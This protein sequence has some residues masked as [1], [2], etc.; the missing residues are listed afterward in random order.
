[1]K[2]SHEVEH[3][4]QVYVTIMPEGA[5]RLRA[6]TEIHLRELAELAPKMSEL[7]DA[8]AGVARDGRL[9]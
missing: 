5:E 3:S 4:G 6:L 9:T 8:V 2:R 7:W 1:M